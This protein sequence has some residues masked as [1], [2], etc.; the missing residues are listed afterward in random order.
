MSLTGGPEGQRLRGGLS[1]RMEWK[2]VQGE[3]S[4]QAGMQQQAKSQGMRKEGR[5]RQ[6]ED[7]PERGA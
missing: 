6:V 1:R 3:C 2:L 5:G 7:R 4:A